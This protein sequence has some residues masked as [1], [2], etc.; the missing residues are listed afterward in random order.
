M[1]SPKPKRCDRCGGTYADADAYFHHRRQRV[2]DSPLG[3]RRCGNELML[4][5]RSGAWVIKPTSA[6]LAAGFAAAVEARQARQEA[7]DGVT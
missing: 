3:A 7:R 6:M 5:D 2:D 4:Q 1:A